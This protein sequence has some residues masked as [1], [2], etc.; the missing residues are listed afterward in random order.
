MGMY[1][2]RGSRE[3]TEGNEINVKKA[4]SLNLYVVM[5]QPGHY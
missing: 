3:E 4:H 5:S 2:G 1:W